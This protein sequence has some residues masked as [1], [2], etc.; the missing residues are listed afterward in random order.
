MAGNTA[1]TN[2]SV[3][4]IVDTVQIHNLSPAYE[5][6]VSVA[7]VRGDT[8]SVF[9]ERKQLYLKGSLTTDTKSYASSIPTQIW[10]IAFLSA[11]MMTLIIIL[12]MSIIVIKTRRVSAV[13]AGNDVE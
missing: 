2:I 13:T 10:L 1:V 9:S 8:K 11:I 5:Y 3:D 6:S 7:A 4:S 12:V